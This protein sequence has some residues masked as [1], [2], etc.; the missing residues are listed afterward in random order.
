MGSVSITDS[1]TVSFFSNYMFNEFAISEANSG[2][3]MTVAALFYCATT[4]A[5]GIIGSKKKVFTS[6]LQ[7]YVF[8]LY[9]FELCTESTRF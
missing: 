7:E 8:Q 9:R 4:F 3:M 2:W 6:A 1:I 5:S